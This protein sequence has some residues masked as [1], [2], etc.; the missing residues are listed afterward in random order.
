MSEVNFHG[1]FGP[2]ELVWL[3]IRADWFS[4]I[5]S[6][7]SAQFQR[8]RSCLNLF[9]ILIK[10][11]NIQLYFCCCFMFVRMCVFIGDTESFHHWI[12]AGVQEKSVGA[13]GFSWTAGGKTVGLQGGEGDSTL[14][15]R[16][17]RQATQ[18]RGVR[19][20]P[21]ALT[22]PHPLASLWCDDSA[23][24]AEPATCSDPPG[25]PLHVPPPYL[26]D[27]HKSPF[28]NTTCQR[29]LWKWLSSG[30]AGNQLQVDE[31]RWIRPRCGPFLMTSGLL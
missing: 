12:R 4:Q 9:L 15:C 22:C 14:G 28:T 1:S 2:P 7:F 19:R 21:G 16:R 10:Y 5:Y 23:S 6:F 3:L 17:G 11:N 13:Q 30:P 24:S 27:G 8:L 25:P 29:K 26:W 31:G 20:N 18:V